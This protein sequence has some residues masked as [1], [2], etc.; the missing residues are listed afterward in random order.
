M[1]NKKKRGL[2][3]ACT[4]ILCLFSFR[5][6]FS[7]NIFQAL[8]HK[9]EVFF[10]LLGKVLTERKLFFCKFV[11]KFSSHKK[12]EEEK[13]IKVSNRKLFLF[14]FLFS[15]SF[16]NTHTYTHFSC[17]RVKK[18]SLFSNNLTS[19]LSLETRYMYNGYLKHN[20]MKIKQDKVQRE[21]REK[22]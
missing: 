5:T 13:E 15:H 6:Y 17:H 7:K 3:T 16:T 1:K 2:A 9:E 22:I 11:Q 21:M 20:K 19:S 8:W 10:S 4:F 12:I 18:I 14:Y